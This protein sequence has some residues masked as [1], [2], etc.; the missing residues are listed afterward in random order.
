M[1]KTQDPED[2]NYFNNLV[3]N[4]YPSSP[5]LVIE[6]INEQYKKDTK[7]GV[8][9]RYKRWNLFNN[10]LGKEQMI[11]YSFQTNS[12]NTDELD[13]R[14]SKYLSTISSRLTNPPSAQKYEKEKAQKCPYTNITFKFTNVT[15]D[16]LAGFGDCSIDDKNLKEGEEVKVIMISKDFEAGKV[17][18]RTELAKYGLKESPTMRVNYTHEPKTE[19]EIKKLL[20]ENKGN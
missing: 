3:T 1:Q 20:D 12:D 4:Y 19:A 6:R 5:N 11:V 10:F 17:A 14:R 7:Y 9:I 16:Y 8:V 13:S 18:F 15:K 2:H